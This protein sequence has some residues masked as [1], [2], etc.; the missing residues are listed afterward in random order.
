MIRT[1]LVTNFMI[2][3]KE[4]KAELL[5]IRSFCRLYMAEPDDDITSPETWK[6]NPGLDVSLKREYMEREVLKAQTLPSY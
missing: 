3:L 4:L 2:T 5:K 1:A 6:A